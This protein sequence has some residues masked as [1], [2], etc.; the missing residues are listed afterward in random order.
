MALHPWSPRL[1]M[2]AFPGP[3]Q[4]ESL[5]MP[6]NDGIRFNNDESRAPLGPKA[7]EP[8]P[9]ESVPRSKF[10]AVRGTFQDDDLVSE[11]Q[12]FGLERE[13]RSKAGKDG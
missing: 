7:Q 4:S 6:G 2:P 8:N 9:K 10:W 3:K 11:S 13:T 1:A 5:A 12:D